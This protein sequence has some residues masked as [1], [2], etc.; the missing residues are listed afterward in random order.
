MK[1]VKLREVEGIYEFGDGQLTFGA[2]KTSGGLH[3]IMIGRP[4]RPG[5]IGEPM[6]DVTPLHFLG[7]KNIESAVVLMRHLTLMVHNMTSEQQGSETP[8]SEVD[9]RTPGPL[10]CCAACKRTARKRK[11][12]IR[13]L[14]KSRRLE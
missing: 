13:K 3:G 9:E 12:E 8:V 2:T 1:T 10:R 14:K 4:S 11:S 5:A 6:P 7:F